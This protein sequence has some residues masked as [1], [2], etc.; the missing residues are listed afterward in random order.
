MGHKILM[1]V[2][3]MNSGGAERVASILANAWVSRGDQVTLMP[4]FSGRGECF[5]KMSPDVCLV[6][7]ADLVSSRIRTLG[8]RFARLCALR[9]FIA[10]ERPD[11]V[12]SFLPEVNVAAVIASIG[13][14]IPVIACERSDPFAMPISRFWK[15]VCRMTYPLA[16][17]L[18]VQTQAVSAKYATSGWPLRRVRVI[19]NPVTQ[20]M[21]DIQYNAD[22]GPSKRLLSI[23]RLDEGKQ[24]GVLIKA[25][26]LIAKSHL[27][28]TL[29]IVGE[30]PLQTALQQQII[31]LG[32][33]GRVELVGRS[34]AII[35]EL[36]NA[37]AFA[38][39]SKYEGFPNVLLEAMAVG[40][41]CVTFDCPSGPREISL[42]GQ[43]ALL[44]PLNDEHAFCLA[45]GKL[46]AD[47][48]LRESLG[49]RARI[50]VRERFALEKVLAQWDSMFKELGVMQ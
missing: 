29:R 37:H 16:D 28:W 7:L 3:S 6:Y 5:Y 49:T 48:G 40:L 20:Q 11:V 13:L 46:M 12:I 25:F 33:I 26:A 43:V 22:D 19:P 23:G 34:P 1:M 35:E 24:F 8:N 32:L 27:G 21:L 47:S 4:T 50:S 39:T 44:V 30:G 17:V 10:S 15:L 42:D 18:L 31:D 2:S 14:G 45:L 41:P 36:A 9:R 38:L